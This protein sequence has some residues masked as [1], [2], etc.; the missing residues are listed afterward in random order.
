MLKTTVYNKLVIII[1]IYISTNAETN[2]I[3]QRLREIHGNIKIYHVI[4]NKKINKDI[5][6][7]NSI[8]SKVDLIRYIKL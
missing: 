8:I 5:K 2:V 6:D 7:L 3:K 1:S 4:P